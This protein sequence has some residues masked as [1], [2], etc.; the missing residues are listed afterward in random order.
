MQAPAYVTVP[1][2]LGDAA[3]VLA[4]DRPPDEATV[5]H[6]RSLADALA[7][8]N[9]AGVT[10][11]VP[12]FST[13]TLHYDPVRIGSYA[14]L[15]AAVQRC[16]ERSVQSGRGVSLKEA[17]SGSPTA[18]VACNHPVEI[19]VCYGGQ[20]GP[21]LGDVAS[22]QG[23]AVEEVIAMHCRANYFV[24]AIGFAPGFAYLGGLPTK[25]HT[26]RRATPRTQ[27]PAG[28]VGIGGALTGVYP[29]ATPGGWNLIGRTPLRLFDP[30]R[31]EPAL[32]KAGDR[33]R[34]RAVTPEECAAWG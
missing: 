32:L 9:L 12:A 31:R 23:L 4:C 19:P 34:F 26:P 14:M 20:F 15:C 17:S 6:I 24:Q 29:L 18:D 28:T 30:T 21:D 2:P 3:M 8:E 5:A 27:V 25:L 11:I 13:I 7:G 10:D 1:R 33:V 22:H 16:L